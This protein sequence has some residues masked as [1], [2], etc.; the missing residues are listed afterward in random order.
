M[1]TNYDVYRLRQSGRLPD[2]DRE[3]ED[4]EMRDLVCEMHE[5]KQRMAEIDCTIKLSV[6]GQRVEKF[7]QLA[8]EL[9]Q[10]VSAACVDWCDTYDHFKD[11]TEP[12]LYATG[13]NPNIPDSD[14]SFDGYMRDANDAVQAVAR[15][16]RWSPT[17]T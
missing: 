12:A 3:Y 17:T 11:V 10:T 15:S 8:D 9:D 6:K 7:L 13:I 4:N 1:I 14:G 5:L 16:L 2:A